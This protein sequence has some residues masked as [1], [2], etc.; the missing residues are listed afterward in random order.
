MT[1]VQTGS[2]ALKAARGW[3]E[4]INTRDLAAMAKILAPEFRYNGMARTPP[5][6]GVR[7]DRQTFLDTVAKSGGGMKKHV[8]MT[9]VSELETADRAVLEVEGYGERHDGGV[10]ANVYCLMFWTRDGQVTELHDYCCT[11]TALAH[12][13][14]L[15]DM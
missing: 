3:I 5:E 4:A 6:L 9:V 14:M 15:R 11:G 12:F 8:E 7:W 1:D 13:S 10:Y 2:S